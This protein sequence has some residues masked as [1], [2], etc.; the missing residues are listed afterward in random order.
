LDQRYGEL[1]IISKEQQL[2]RSTAAIIKSYAPAVCAISGRDH[3][4]V[5]LMHVK[6]P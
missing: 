2:A 5:V 1:G 6:P 4:S 3:T